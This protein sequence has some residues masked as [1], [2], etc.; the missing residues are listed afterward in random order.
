MWETI[1]FHYLVF[2]FQVVKQVMPTSSG[3][4]AKGGVHP[5]PIAC[6]TQGYRETNPQMLL[7]Q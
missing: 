7:Q 3:H 5:G 6:A 2:P 4:C 1:H